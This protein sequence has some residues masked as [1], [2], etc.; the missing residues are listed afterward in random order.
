MWRKGRSVLWLPRILKNHSNSHQV[1]VRAL[2]SGNSSSPSHYGEKFYATKP[3][4]KKLD[5]DRAVSDAERL[6][7]YQTSFLSL[8]WLLSD[9]VANLAVHL[10]KLVGRNHPLLKTAKFMLYNEKSA[11]QA[12]GLIVLLVSKAAGYS[13]DSIPEMDQDKSCG[14]LYTQRALAEVTEMIRVSH[15][16]H[17]SLVNLQSEPKDETGDIIFGNK[18]SLLTGDYLLGH[19]SLE[20]ANLRNQAITGVISSA[21]RDFTESEFIGDRDNQN[22]VLPSKP[23]AEYGPPSGTLSD[24]DDDFF[25][26]DVLKPTNVNKYLGIPEKEWEVRHLLHAGHLLAR[27]CQ[28]ALNLAKQPEE[29]QKYGFLFGKHLSLA[30]QACLD[31]KPFRN[32][33]LPQGD[34]FNLIG[35][36]VLF[37][38]SYDPTAY[39]EIEKGKHSIENIDFVKL[40]SLIRLGP[41]L[42]LTKDLQLKHTRKALNVLEYF[43]PSEART[44]LENILVAMQDL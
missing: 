20:L 42:K 17:N 13:V 39:E 11:M 41:G 21:I 43:P 29:L 7:G 22:N 37:H 6:V 2:A 18:I 34:T 35:A 30:W 12:W 24:L 27:S 26:T 8:R 31:Y 28:G 33:T 19:A 9:E 23:N 44:A 25:E 10:R 38:L 3:V 32:S 40:H 1:H 15:L 4:P 14:L 16:V 5:W 36:P